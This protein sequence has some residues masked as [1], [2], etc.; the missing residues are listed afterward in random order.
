[1]KTVNSAPTSTP[2]NSTRPRFLSMLCISAALA[3]GIA[4]AAMADEAALPEVLL[5]SQSVT[6]P[7][8][9]VLLVRTAM[10]PSTV[11][12]S[13]PIGMANTICAE[14]AQIPHTGQNG[15][16]CGYDRLVRR[17]C[18]DLPRQC[19]I[20]ERTKRQVCAPQGRECHNE[21]IEMARVCTWLETE[22]VRR[23]VVQS[24]SLRTLKLKF[25]G[26][27]RLAAGETETY[28]LH[29]AQNHLD[30][31]DATYSLTPIATKSAVKIKAKDGLFTGFKDTI[32]IKGD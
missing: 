2:L 7:A 24:S 18:R 25:K 16:R 14:T 1:M 30:G 17:V 31:A 13:L 27:A 32:T 9:D 21:S 4:A 6:L 10:T 20:D 28:E 19:R 5:N 11:E 23:E 3:C 29:G 8:A 26:V 12:L 15:L 22:C